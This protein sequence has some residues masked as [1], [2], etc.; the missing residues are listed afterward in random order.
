MTAQPPTHAQHTVVV[1]VIPHL[2]QRRAQELA[3]WLAQPGRIVGI[4]QTPEDL[5]HWIHKSDA[6]RQHQLRHQNRGQ[7]NAS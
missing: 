5:A 7:L 4:I 6:Q 2:T 1:V 3:D